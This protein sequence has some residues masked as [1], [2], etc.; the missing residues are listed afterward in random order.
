M[1]Q[2]KPWKSDS[3]RE[4]S[5]LLAKKDFL[6]GIE[7]SIRSAA[8]TYGLSYSTLHDR[9]R[10]IQSTSVAHHHQQLLTEQEEKAIVRFWNTLDD[11]GHPVNMRIL[12]GFAKSLLAVSKC[13]EVG[14]H[15]ATRLLNCHPELAVR[16][17]QCLDYQRANTSDPAIIKD[18]F[19]KVIILHYN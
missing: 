15:W 11:Y 1:G 19:R 18:F 9:Q 7:P 10:G 3:E 13:R 12:K 14:K 6:A 16:F 2:V 4:K 5:I 17:S 8:S